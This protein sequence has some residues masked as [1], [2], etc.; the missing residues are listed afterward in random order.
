[1]TSQVC[2]DSGVV[3]KL[4]LDEPDSD[5]AEALWAGWIEAGR[6]PVAPYLFAFEITAVLRK[7][8][9]RGTLTDAEGR[10]ALQ[11]ALAFDVVLLSPDGLHL[12]AWSLAARFNLSTAYDAHYLALAEELGCEFWTSDQR[13]YNAV[14]DRLAW[15]HW[16]A[17]TSDLV[18]TD[19][20][21]TL[22][23]L[24]SS[25]DPLGSVDHDRSLYGE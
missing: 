12:R 10:H 2:V 24:G 15:V 20:L 19:P 22:I 16:L 4:V 25:G 1:M 11:Q 9:Y 6:Q 5:Q 18:E 7:H 17:Q 13:L 8:V 23:G 3:L 14:Q 21:T